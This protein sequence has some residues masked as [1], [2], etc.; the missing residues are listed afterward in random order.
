[1]NKPLRQVI[2]DIIHQAMPHRGFIVHLTYDQVN[3]EFG[4]IMYR[5]NFNEFK[6]EQQVDL[7]V[8][9]QTVMEKISAAGIPAY[10]EMKGAVP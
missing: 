6:P 2:L 8:H 1:M 10:L 9:M 4:I 7:I 3:A 5:E